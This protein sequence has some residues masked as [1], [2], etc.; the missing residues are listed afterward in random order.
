MHQLITDGMARAGGL[1]SEQAATVGALVGV[2]QRHYRSNARREDYYRGRVGV[3]DLGVTVTKNMASRLS[4]HVDWAAKCVNWWADRVLFQGFTCTDEGVKKALDDLARL[5]DFPNLVRNVVASALKTS[6]AFIA[7]TRGD[8]RAGEPAALVRGYPATAASALFSDAKQRI[9][10]GL[11]VADTELAADRLTR[12]P[13][14]AYVLTDTELITLVKRGSAWAARTERHGMGRVPMEKVAYHGTLEQP[15]GSSRITKA[16]M[17]IVDDAQRELQNMAATAAFSAAPQKYLMGADKS[18]ITAVQ[19]SPFGAYIGSL[20]ATTPNRNGA[21][22]AYGQLPQ[23]SMQPHS[24]YMRLLAS[25]FSDATNVPLSSL[26]FS[27][28]NP[29]SA[30]AIIASKEDAIVDINAFISSVAHS[31]E[32]VAGMALSVIDGR[33]TFADVATSTDVGVL[34][35]DPATPSPVSMSQ[36]VQQRVATFPWMVN[37]DVPLRDLGYSGDKLAQLQSD[38][39][40]YNASAALAEIG[41]A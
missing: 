10:C 37:S 25:M 18:A 15:F 8:E 13:R 9:D 5:N 26:G 17:G 29:S 16:V 27:T 28:T 1:T 38:R 34:F 6:P 33:A 32:N 21:T 11:V 22:P 35:A 12:V 40:A 14:L 19:N 7:V 24:D 30:D 3:K 39:R 4:P 41:G 2:W 36:A 31:L 20:F 23:L